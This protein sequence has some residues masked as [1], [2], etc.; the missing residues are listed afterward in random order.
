MYNYVAYNRFYKRRFLH[1]S[2]TN[3]EPLRIAQLARSTYYHPRKK[4]Q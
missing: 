1:L 3:C 4:P 2:F